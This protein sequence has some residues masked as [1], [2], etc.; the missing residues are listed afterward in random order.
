MNY[1]RQILLIDYPLKQGLKLM[2]PDA[3]KKEIVLLIDY[4]LKQGLK[5]V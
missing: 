3:F 4:P 2:I 1:C 5:P